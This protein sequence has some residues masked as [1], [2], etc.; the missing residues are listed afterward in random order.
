MSQ[1]ITSHF[2]LF[3]LEPTFDV[4]ERDLRTRYLRISREL[5]PDFQQRAGG[6][7]D[8][9]LH[10]SAQVNAAYDTL[11]DPIRRAEHLLLLA[12]GDTAADDKT[13]P[14]EVLTQTLM[15]REEIDEAKAAG[16]A[17]ALATLAVQVR[18]GHDD[19]ARRIG[20]L[21]RALPG[22]AAH[23]SALRA[24]LNA[25]RYYERMLEQL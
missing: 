22:D 2:E 8:A 4:D 16:A 12:G 23:R 6:V 25:I 14:P 1:R 17:E 7:S 24:A 11:R 18:A 3:G 5:H 19:W 20:E 15:L 21:A 13:V 10:G 9:A